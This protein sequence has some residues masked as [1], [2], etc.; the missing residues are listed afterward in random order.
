MMMMCTHTVCAHVGVCVSFC[1]RTRD[2]SAME[3]QPRVCTHQTRTLCTLQ[4][5]SKTRKHAHAQKR[6]HALL[7]TCN[8]KQNRNGQKITPIRI[9]LC[10]FIYIH[11][12]HISE[13]Y[14]DEVFSRAMQ[15]GR[16]ALL[17]ER[18]ITLDGSAGPH[19]L[20]YAVLHTMPCARDRHDEC[21]TGTI[22]MRVVCAASARDGIMHAL[23]G[24]S[25]ARYINSG[26]RGGICA[27]QVGVIILLMLCLP[28]T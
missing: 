16:V 17:H 13:H 3:T 23:L 4:A 7:R 21:Q 27:P 2:A 24:K 5:N 26:Q 1:V 9:L 20:F 25:I 11:A 14:N 10:L 15:C 28:H 12:R 19:A 8:N 22:Y 18:K 6:A